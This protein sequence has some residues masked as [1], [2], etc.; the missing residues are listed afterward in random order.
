MKKS[1][2]RKKNV[3]N[4]SRTQSSDTRTSILGSKMLNCLKPKVNELKVQL[5]VQVGKLFHQELQS[6]QLWSVSNKK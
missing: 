3:Q 2:K 6:Q 1:P 5:Y 4:F